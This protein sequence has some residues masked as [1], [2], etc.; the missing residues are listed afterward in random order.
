MRFRADYIH[1]WRGQQQLVVRRTCR[2]DGPGYV[3]VINGCECVW[4]PTREG[5]VGAL[6]RRTAYRRS[7]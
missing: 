6:L 3:G 2:P 1:I 7:H 4:S 5:A